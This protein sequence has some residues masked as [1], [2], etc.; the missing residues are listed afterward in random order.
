MGKA[1]QQTVSVYLHLTGQTGYG[2]VTEQPEGPSQVCER[3]DNLWYQTS[4]LQPLVTDTLCNYP[5]SDF[6][7]LTFD[8]PGVDSSSREHALPPLPVTDIGC[9]ASFNAAADVA[10]GA[11]VETQIVSAEG[12]DSTSVVLHR[13]AVELRHDP[14]TEFLTN[15][16]VSCDFTLATQY[17]EPKVQSCSRSFV[18]ASCEGP[19]ILSKDCG[20]GEALECVLGKCAGG[21]LPEPFEACGSTIIRPDA[22]GNAAVVQGESECC[23]A[24]SRE[25]MCVPLLNVPTGQ[26]DVRRCELQPLSS[27][28]DHSKRSENAVVD[29]EDSDFGQAKGY[30]YAAVLPAQWRRSVG[31]ARARGH[32]APLVTAVL[33]LALAGVVLTVVGAVVVRRRGA[34]PSGDAGGSYV[35]MRG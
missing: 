11:A 4:V 5:G 6:V 33:A 17:E 20:D 18:L 28:A 10:S 12:I 19:G 27:D 13:F 15:L 32:D 1:G 31:A 16:H 30:A 25:L 29:S 9:F 35:L 22:A 2:D 21:S 7:E 34:G 26:Q 8:F 3:F 23:Q 14:S 24:C